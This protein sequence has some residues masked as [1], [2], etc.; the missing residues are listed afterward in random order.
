MPRDERE[1]SVFPIEL[2]L[3][4]S[5]SKMIRERDLVPTG[6]LPRG[7]GLAKARNQV[8][9]LVAGTQVLGPSFVFLRDIGREWIRVGAARI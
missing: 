1:V 6:S 5:K 8:S 4:T 7:L 3:F 2:C 9:D